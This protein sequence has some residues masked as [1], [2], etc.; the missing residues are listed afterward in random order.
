MNL[1]CR[2]GFHDW[3]SVLPG[4]KTVMYQEK[5]WYPMSEILNGNVCARCGKI[6]AGVLLIP[7]GWNGDAI[8]VE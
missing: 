7:A 4:T 3:V 1:R 5:K 6:K 8:T 2:L